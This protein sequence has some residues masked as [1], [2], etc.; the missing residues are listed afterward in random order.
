MCS[1]GWQRVNYMLSIA[2]DCR[3]GGV[4]LQQRSQTNDGL[5]TDH[6]WRVDSTVELESAAAIKSHTNLFFWTVAIEWL[7]RIYF[8]THG[9]IEDI[10]KTKQHKLQVINK[11]ASWD[12]SVSW[13]APVQ[14]ALHSPP[15]TFH[16]CLDKWTTAP[17][18][19][20]RQYSTVQYSTSL[21]SPVQEALSSLII[22]G[23]H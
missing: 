10:T 6:R 7:H 5:S 16:L 9:I 8:C 11:K 17:T 14:L 18:C 19:V 20:H 1:V 22:L 21:H 15:L 3:A 2:P 23:M 13:E 4:P 12:H